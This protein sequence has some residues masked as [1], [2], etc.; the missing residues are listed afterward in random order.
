MFRNWNSDLKANL[1]NR[2]QEM[3]EWISDIEDTVEE[4]NI[5]VKENVK[6]RK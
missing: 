1:T 3:E 5:L 2:V 4:M 6:S